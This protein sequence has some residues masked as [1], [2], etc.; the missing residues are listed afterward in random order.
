MR[1]KI[2]LAV[3]SFVVLS[4]WLFLAVR[5][6]CLYDCE[7]YN[8]VDMSRGC[9]SFFESIGLDADI[10]HGHIYADGELKATHCWVV[11][12]LPFGTV[13][14]ESTTLMFCSNSDVYSVNR[15]TS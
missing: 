13:E 5:Q 3:L 15:V 4:S 2:F 7:N 1:L 9:K 6:A 8:C 11:L 14:F 12:N 10:A